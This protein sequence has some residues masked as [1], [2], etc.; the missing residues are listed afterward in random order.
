[1]QVCNAQRAQGARVTYFQNI[2]ER[3]IQ[4]TLYAWKAAKCMTTLGKFR[5]FKVQQSRKYDDV[6]IWPLK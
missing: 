2:R 4:F 5:V 3:K 6:H 1:M